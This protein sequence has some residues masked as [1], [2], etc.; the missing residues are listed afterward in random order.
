MVRIFVIF[1]LLCAC[2][3]TDPAALIAA[4]NAGLQSQTQQAAH[5]AT[6]DQSARTNGQ[7]RLEE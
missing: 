1:L 5:Q 2:A 3:P 7:M 6:A 4:G